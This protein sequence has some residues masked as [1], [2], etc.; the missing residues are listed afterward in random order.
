MYDK[1]WCKK[2]LKFSKRVS[3]KFKEAGLLTN[4]LSDLLK[5]FRHDFLNY[6]VLISK[7]KSINI[8]FR[9]FQKGLKVV[10]YF[11]L[12]PGFTMKVNKEHLQ[13]IYIEREGSTLSDY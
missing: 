13:S 2:T 4:Y 1:K 8:S 5:I 10:V 9:G 3:F 11:N 7:E 6:K 12:V